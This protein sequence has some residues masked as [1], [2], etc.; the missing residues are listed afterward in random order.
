MTRINRRARWDAEY[1]VYDLDN[2]GV[3]TAS[4]FMVELDHL[5][6]MKGIAAGSPEAEEAR[7]GTRSLVEDLLTFDPNGDGQ[8]TREEFY[9]Y[10]E[11][12]FIRPG[13]PGSP[14]A[15]FLTWI[16]TAFLG[17]DLDS[18]GRLDLN[19]YLGTLLQTTNIK[20]TE[21]E[22]RAHFVGLCDHYGQGDSLSEDEFVA[23]A[24]EI[25]CSPE[26][27]FFWWPVP[28]A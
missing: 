17:F 24:I 13:T 7:G 14:S 10:I 15:R 20:V 26:P 9:Q 3:L 1:D 22:L 16:R 18:N 11:Q 5:L 23:A 8:I 28:G 25:W 19:D 6:E 4:D 27:A 21:E 2:D 12:E